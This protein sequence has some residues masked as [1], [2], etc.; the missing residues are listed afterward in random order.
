[1]YLK[2]ETSPIYR[3]NF[4]ELNANFF[5]NFMDHELNTF[6]G[7]INISVCE[8]EDILNEDFEQAGEI[9]FHAYNLDAFDL[10]VDKD[11][12]SMNY[13]FECMDDE[14]ADQACCY[15]IFSKA[16]D[17]LEKKLNNKW[18]DM[19]I[20][21]GAKYLITLDRLFINEKY[22]QKGIATYILNNL[23]YI[24]NTYYNINSIIVVG[25]CKPDDNT[26]E[27]LNAQKSMLK[28]VGYKTYKNNND[29]C[30]YGLIYKED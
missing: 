17:A 21:D 11:E 4:L 14:D 25:I 30:F 20:T 9:H 27:M 2:F 22:R 18:I 23:T 7:G 1:M 26:K 5:D 19:W 8:T 16:Y 3:Q 10:E 24:L 6:C 13:L 12:Y 15:H 28:K 29:T